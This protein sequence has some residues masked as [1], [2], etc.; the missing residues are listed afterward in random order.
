MF[1]FLVLKSK[2]VACY[3]T[4]ICGLLNLGTPLN[5]L[6]GPPIPIEPK[7]YPSAQYLVILFKNN[8]IIPCACLLLYFPRVV[9]IPTEA[10]YFIFSCHL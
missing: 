9:K 3:S 10:S 1:N 4:F 7:D 2:G 5:I 8:L 6:T